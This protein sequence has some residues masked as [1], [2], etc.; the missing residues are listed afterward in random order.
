MALAFNAAHGKSPDSELPG[1][2]LMARRLE[3]VAQAEAL[4]E[5]ASTEDGDTD[6]VYGDVDHNG[7]VRAHTRKMKK[8]GHPVDP[9]AL[10][11]RYTVVENSYI[12]A[13]FKHNHKSWLQDFEPGAFSKLADYLLCNKA[14]T[15]EA[16]QKR[17]TPKHV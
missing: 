16:S 2:P 14:C 9:E 8:V 10:R 5:V 1:I 13:K 7:S 15:L 3:Y 4:T 12:W 11:A 6:V 17:N